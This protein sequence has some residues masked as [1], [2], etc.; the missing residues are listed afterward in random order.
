MQDDAQVS[1]QCRDLA[2]PVR[3]R[4]KHVALA[5][6]AR[7]PVDGLVLRGYG[8][9]DAMAH[10]HPGGVENRPLVGVLGCERHVA[11]P[12][13]PADAHPQ[14]RLAGEAV[15]STADGLGGPENRAPT[16]KHEHGEQEL[17]RESERQISHNQL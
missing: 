9:A 15:P 5:A 7:T 4:N 17:V 10:A 2:Q 3:H 16:G 6:D 14:R 11:W 8:G 13:A 1:H 12:L